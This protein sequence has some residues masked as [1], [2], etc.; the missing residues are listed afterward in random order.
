MSCLAAC[1]C[2]PRSRGACSPPSGPA[3]RGRRGPRRRRS[4]S[5][6]ASAAAS[7]SAPPSSWKTP[8]ESPRRSISKRLLVVERRRC[9]CRG[10]SRVASSMRSSAV[11]ITER[12]RSPRKS[13]F[14][15]PS[16][17]TPCISYW[18]TI[19]AS[20]ASAPGLGL[21][22]DRQVLG[23]RLVGDDDRRGVDAVLAA[24]ALEALARRRSPCFASGSA[25]YISRRSAAGDVA[26]L[27]ALDAARGSAD[28]GVSR[29]M[30]SGG[31]A[32]AILS[33]S[34]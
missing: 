7:A 1:S 4:T 30:T 34:A 8:I 32:L 17:S 27:V 26:V 20:A 13:I 3:G 15:R 25:S 5:A 2:G 14:N 24:Q 33:P 22:L 31:I 10:A 9:R 28:S 6:R 23:E 12:L 19:G 16:S 18:V 21:A 29:P 11:S